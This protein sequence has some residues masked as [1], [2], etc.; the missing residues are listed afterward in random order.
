MQ[1]ISVDN[2]DSIKRCRDCNEE[3]NSDAKKCRHCGSYQNWQYRLNLSNSVIALL[4][5]LI[6]VSTLFT[7][8]VIQAAKKDN[9][10]VIMVFQGIENDKITILASNTGNRPAIIR[11]VELYIYT[12]ESRQTVFY[13]SPFQSGPNSRGL[14][15]Q[16]QKEVYLNIQKFGF[17]TTRERLFEEFSYYDAKT[18]LV[19]LVTNYDASETKF[20]FHG[21]GRDYLEF[22]KT[23]WQRRES[24]DIP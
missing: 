6:S 15:E 8:V 4:I 1:E 17:R 12:D 11:S 22:I 10:S 21:F 7:Q 23:Q 18:R 13:L 2:Q 19:I 20:E 16:K 5:A 9:S 24:Q 3:I 14:P